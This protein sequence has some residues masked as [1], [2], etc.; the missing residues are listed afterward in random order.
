MNIEQLQA[1]AQFGGQLGNLL[2]DA[3]LI[4]RNDAYRTR[5]LEACKARARESALF[6]RTRPDH[7]MDIE[8]PRYIQLPMTV[9]TME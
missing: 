7:A 2:H 4:R 9:G 5:A 6:F 3:L 8:K 1:P